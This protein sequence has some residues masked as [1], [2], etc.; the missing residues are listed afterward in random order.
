MDLTLSGWF[1]VLIGAAIGMVALTLAT[2]SASAVPPANNS[3]FAQSRLAKLLRILIVMGF[4]AP[5]FGNAFACW[6]S[7]IGIAYV[8]I[9]FGLSLHVRNQFDSNFL[10]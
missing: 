1:F 9:V 5:A 4:P 6:I 10:D 2:I 3:S 8:L 7:V